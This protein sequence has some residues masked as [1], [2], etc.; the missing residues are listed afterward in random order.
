MDVD[1]DLAPLRAYPALW[2]EVHAAFDRAMAKRYGAGFDAALRAGLMKIAT[3]DQPPRMRLSELQK[4]HGWPPPDS[5]LKPLLR[6]MAIA[7]STNLLRIVEILEKRGWPKKAMVGAQAG[8]TL[9]LVIQHADLATQE[10]YLPMLEQA[11]RDGGLPASSLA[12][13]IDRIR[14]RNNKLQLYGSQLHQDEKTGATVFFPIEDEARVDE[15]RKAMGLEELAEYA[16]RFGIVYE[17]R[18]G[19]RSSRPWPSPIRPAVGGEGTGRQ[20]VPSTPART[21]RPIDPS[22]HELIGRLR[23]RLIQIVG[24]SDRR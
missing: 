1:T 24:W 2:S 6:E 9:F 8:V 17:G 12:L 23:D 15:R 4:K 5:L 10:K 22:R 13:L 16:R 20:T 11:V 19:S 7:D 21:P 3:L 14:V 18:E